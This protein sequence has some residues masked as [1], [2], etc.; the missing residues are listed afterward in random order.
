MYF[1]RQN[2]SALNAIQGNAEMISLST[3]I[4]TKT[5]EINKYIQAV[6]LRIIGVLENDIYLWM[7]NDVV[8]RALSRSLVTMSFELND[9]NNKIR[10][11]VYKIGEKFES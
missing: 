7:D 8:E 2:T 6:N 9:Y 3:M 10:N 4:L 5:I 1:E 11:S